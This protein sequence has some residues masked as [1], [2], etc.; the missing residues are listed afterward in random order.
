[1]SADGKRSKTTVKKAGLAGGLLASAWHFVPHA[2]PKAPTWVVVPVVVVGAV[3]VVVS[4]V[5][6]AR[7]HRRSPRR[8]KEQRKAGTW[9]LGAAYGATAEVP[10]TCAATAGEL[11][12]AADGVRFVAPSIESWIA[13]D[14]V[15]VVRV[16]PSWIE[17]VGGGTTLRIRPK[18]FSDRERLLWELA[19]RCNPAMERGLDEAHRPPSATTSKAAVKTTKPADI[20]DIQLG[21]SGLA[22]A[23][24]PDAARNPAPPR[25]SGLGCGL[26]PGTPQS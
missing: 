19:V 6:A 11:T 5:H 24:V 10:G 4:A 15:E 20:A 16:R 3:M 9:P 14:E 1:M 13:A 23:L 8:T 18:S 17:I 21:S 22:S 26:F 12:L 25:R 7:N 2:L